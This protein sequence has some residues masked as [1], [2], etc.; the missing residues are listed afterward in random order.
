MTFA[1]N[2]DDDNFFK[3]LSDVHLVDSIL[4]EFFVRKFSTN[5][6]FLPILFSEHRPE[7]KPDYKFKALKTVLFLEV[8]TAGCFG[9]R[10]FVSDESHEQR[11]WYVTWNSA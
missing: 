9:Y 1:Q 10:P 8:L 6:L 3:I 4:K 5:I 11:R 7:V 2:Y